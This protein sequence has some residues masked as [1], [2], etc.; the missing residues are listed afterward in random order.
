MSLVLALD[1]WD[2]LKYHLISTDRADAAGSVVQ[3]L[4]DH[5]YRIADISD[6]FRGDPEIKAA[7]SSYADELDDSEEYDEDYNDDEDYDE[8]DDY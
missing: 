3:L 8:D 2:E 1:M 7:L 5:D 6:V 4:I